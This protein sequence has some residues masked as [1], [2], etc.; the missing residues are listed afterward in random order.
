MVIL[1]EH[2][3]CQ[4]IFL[5]FLKF[6]YTGEV[7]F[8]NDRVVGLLCLADK[9]NVESLHNLAIEYMHKNSVTPHLMNSLKWYSWVKLLNCQE[10]FQN[11]WETICSSF[12]KLIFLPDIWCSLEIDFLCEILESSSIIVDCEYSVYEL[13]KIWLSCEDHNKEFVSHAQRIL[14]LIRFSM[15]TPAQLFEIEEKNDF[16]VNPKVEKLLTGLLMKAHK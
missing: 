11:C 1:E 15:M 6:L 5:Y 13:C 3:E 14:P 12:Q 7:I 4:K 8:N 9:Y 10:I 16:T 2:S